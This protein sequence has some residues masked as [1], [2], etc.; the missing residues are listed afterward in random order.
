MSSLLP[1][2]RPRR[3]DEKAAEAPRGERPDVPAPDEDEQP[4]FAAEFDHP[5]GRLDP[6]SR[7]EP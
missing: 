4:D 6:T 5:S 1:P 2:E 7:W 3:P